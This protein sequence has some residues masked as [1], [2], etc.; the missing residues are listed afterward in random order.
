MGCYPSKTNNIN[1]GHSA[2]Y[3]GAGLD[4]RPL[5]DLKYI[6]KFNY[7]D[8]LPN[9]EFGIYEYT[10]NNI[11][12]FNNPNFILNLDNIM[13]ENKFNLINDINDVRVYSNQ[14][15]IIYYNVNIAIPELFFEIQHYIKDFDTLIVAGYDPDSII[16][17][18]NNN[19][20]HFIGYEGTY[21]DKNVYDDTQNS[22]IYKLH[23]NEINYRFYKYTYITNQGEFKSFTTWK[24]F[25]K[26]YKYYT[27]KDKIDY[28]K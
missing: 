24:S 25:Y 10:K 16:L 14:K 8:S 9:S 20:I 28:I 23:T 18:A 26:Y 12:Y 1:I 17:D 6:T 3:I 5:Q 4:M 27:I 21:Y 13:N 19:K 22:I 7:I 15:Q 11:N 2:L